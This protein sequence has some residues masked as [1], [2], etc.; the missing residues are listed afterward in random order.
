MM[1]GSLARRLRV[2]RAE[3]GLTLREAASRTG[4][5]KE[6]ISD[7]ERGLRHPHDPTLAKIAK[8]YGVPIQ[9]LL[10]EPEFSL[11]G[12]A[13]APEA[14]PADQRSEEKEAGQPD[15]D[16]SLEEERQII[17]QSAG[18]LKAHIKAMKRLKELRVD[19][20]EEIKKGTGPH[21]GALLFQMEMADK[22]FRTLLEE[23]GALGFAKAVKAG[24]EMAQPEAIPLC[25]ELLRRLAELEALSAEA[26]VSS[27]AASL[28]IYEEA[29]KGVSQVESWMQ[30]E[31]E[32]REH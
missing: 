24:H 16:S 8:G 11:A 15:V 17:P 9:E 3:R 31:S 4:V 2:L 12:K 22:G 21:D 19:E 7:I 6:T 32:R 27:S 28:D 23:T 18:M 1:Q 25:H 10:E 20:M 26:R 29:V 5:A 13:E 30:E 14:G